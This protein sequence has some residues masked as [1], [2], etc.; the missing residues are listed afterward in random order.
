MEGRNNKAVWRAQLIEARI[1]K[2]E[3]NIPDAMSE[4]EQ[5]IA[6]IETVTDQIRQREEILSIEPEPEPQKI[7]KKLESEPVQDNQLPL[8]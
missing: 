4:I 2:Y 8:F 7:S 5:A 6:D 3:N 1:H